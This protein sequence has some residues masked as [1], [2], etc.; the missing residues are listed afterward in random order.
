MTTAQYLHSLHQRYQAGNTTEHSFRGDLQQLLESLLPGVQATNEPKR[1]AC[2]AP[3]FILNRGEV[4]LG[5]VEAKDIGNPDLDGKKKTGNKEQFD[6]YKASLNNLIF[7]DYLDFHWYQEGE[8]VATVRIGDV[9]GTGV[10]AKPENYARF[11]NLIRDFGTTVG[12]TIKNP[13]KLAK[14]MAGK[15]RLLAEVITRALMSDEDR[16]ENSSLKEQLNA[17]QQFLIHDITPK[18]F[19]D[20]YAQTITFESPPQL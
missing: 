10:E 6:R 18:G 19:A 1:Q 11:E 12:Q 9:N 3:D 2:G 4:P 15:A 17:F 20:V 13:K 14:M 8:L 5:F 7:T 16:Q